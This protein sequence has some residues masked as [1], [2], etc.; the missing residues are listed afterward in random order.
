MNSLERFGWA[1]L[2]AFAI[3]FVAG[4]IGVFW[5][6]DWI[7]AE[8]AVFGLLTLMVTLLGL[9]YFRLTTDFEKKF[10][11]L[12]DRPLEA[13]LRP[14]R[15]WLSS[16]GIVSFEALKDPNVE[17]FI[18]GVSCINFLSENEADLR[19]AA[20]R[21]A[22]FRFVLTDPSV[23]FLGLYDL[24]MPNQAGESELQ[25]DIRRAI[26]TIERLGS[27]STIQYR[28]YGGIPMFSAL[29][30]RD[31]SQDSIFLE[32]YTY[33][34]AP[35]NRPGFFVTRAVSKRWHSFFRTPW[36]RFGKL[37]RAWEVG[38]PVRKAG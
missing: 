7:S 30:V 14:R 26:A 11:V 3:L 29:W 35:A 38:R 6:P 12:A 33:G 18:A 32:F 1:N 25:S 31:R 37:A 8:Q 4:L 5:T 9:V 22:T 10:A 34:G 2:A 20:S 27:G 23:G 24:N 28:L 17:V 13:L 36:T 21:G 15:D 19:V 16:G